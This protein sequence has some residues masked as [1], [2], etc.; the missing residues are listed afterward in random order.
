MIC[1]LMDSSPKAQLLCLTTNNFSFDFNGIHPFK[2]WT[3][4]RSFHILI[5]QDQ[6]GKSH[7]KYFT[8]FSKNLLLTREEEEK[9]SSQTFTPKNFLRDVSSMGEVFNIMFVV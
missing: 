1:I 9:K 2:K 8:N 5:N 3:S 4:I 6:H 7:K